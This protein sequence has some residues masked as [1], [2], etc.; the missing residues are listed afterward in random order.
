MYGNCQNVI[1]SI[2]LCVLHETRKASHA[3]IILFGTKEFCV[4]QNVL[5]FEEG[6]CKLIERANVRI[7]ENVLLTIQ[8]D[9]CYGNSK[10]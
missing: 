3:L 2:V 4:P 10:P 7:L 5:S 6:E 9:Y 8:E 1:A